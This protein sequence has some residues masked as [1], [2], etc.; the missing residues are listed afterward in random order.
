MRTLSNQVL[1]ILC[2]VIT[3][4]SSLLFTPVTFAQLDSAAE[5]IAEVKAA[6]GV[7]S[8]SLA[9]AAS[10][11]TNLEIQSDETSFDET[12]GIAKAKGNVEIQYQGTTIQADQAEYHQ[13][14]GD[15]FARGN[16]VIYKDGSSYTAEETIYNINTGE[17]QAS[18]LRGGLVPIYYDAS[19]IKIPTKATDMI[20]MTDSWFTTDDN[21]EPTFRIKAKRIR[22][23]PGE[24]VTFKNLKVY[25][26]NTPILWL[27]YLSQP[28]NDE[29]GY[30]FTPG[31]NSAWGAFL[32]N[33]YGFMIGDHTLAQV[34]F[35]LRSTRG[36]AGGIEFRSQ[37]YRSNQNFGRLNLYYANDSAPNTN[38]G[39]GNRNTDLSSERYR[40]NL[41]HRVYFPGPEKSTLYLDI[42]INKLSDAFLYNDFFP[43]EFTM[44]PNPDNII[45]LVKADPRG[46]LSLTGRF[47]LND[48][49]QTDSR[50]PELALDVTRQPILGSGLFYQGYTTFGVIEE[51]LA[52]D[53]R[54]TTES[55]VN[56]QTNLLKMLDN[57]KAEVQNGDLVTVVNTDKG[58]ESVILQRDFDETASRSLLNNLDQLLDNRSFTRFDTYHEVL[59]PAAIGGWLSVVPRAG[60]GYTKYMDVGARNVGDRDRTILHAGIDASFKVSKVYPNAISEAMGINEL[61]HITQPYVNYSFVSADAPADGFATRIDRL[62]PTTRLRPLD[63]P[64]FTAVDDIQ[65]WNIARVGMVNRLQTKRNQG[66]FG[67]LE[68]N[69]FFDTY[70][71]DP[72]FD[73]DFSNLFNNV[74]WA[75]LPWLVAQLNS[76]IPLLDQK[77]GFTE[78]VSNFTFMPTKNFQFS[79]G[80]YFLDDH[81]FFV[82][83]N[84]LSVGTYTRLGDN[85]G[86][87]TMHRF[88]A[89]DSTL[90][91]QQYQIHRDL[92]AWTASFGG[93]LR[94]NRGGTNEWGVVMSFTLKAFP[95]VSLPIDLMPGSFVGGN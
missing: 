44:D 95:T 5:K 80:N 71:D 23:Y 54:N 88:E 58:E 55:R 36:V 82:D 60:I 37:R 28:L 18:S 66:T 22:M 85:W 90:E 76:Q 57:G 79:V 1:P 65:S 41:Q 77:T 9:Q 52:T 11:A 56:N 64:L 93:I 7:D 31:Y 61:R 70:I 73:R 49:F 15:V 4:I 42:D 94:D 33:Q 32:L 45:N 91:I 83:S 8:S 38:F 30:F 10:L 3:G 81:P 40:I 34:R 2:G 26:G 86:F 74:T 75:P 48:F 43:R 69:T 62:T 25:A 20:E 39:G 84:Q 63:L 35:D 51:N 89:T 27:P 87:S 67:W 46:T 17:M 50:L 13:V 21:S 24:R 19:D 12:M 6:S 47:Q 59:Y 68:L 14:T 53:F 92:A 16:V 78:V 29:L 72:E